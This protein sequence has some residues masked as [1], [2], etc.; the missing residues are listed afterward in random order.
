VKYGEKSKA[1]VEKSDAIVYERPRIED[2]GT[3]AE[4]T[5]GKGNASPDFF[6]NWEDRN[7][8]GGYS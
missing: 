4:L 1:V 5:A 6:G 3:L 7:G 2:Y 8:G